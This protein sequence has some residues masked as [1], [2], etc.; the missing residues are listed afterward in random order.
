MADKK[1]LIK[2]H[3][4]IFYSPGIL[5]LEYTHVLHNQPNFNNFLQTPVKETYNI[6]RSRFSLAALH[7]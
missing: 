6:L 5:Q 2:L 1:I 7:P 3:F 4:T